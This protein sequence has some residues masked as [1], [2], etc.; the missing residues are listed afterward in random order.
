[1]SLFACLHIA[2]LGTS[3]Q[4]LNVEIMTK[5]SEKFI[6]NISDTRL[7]D[8]ERLTFALSLFNLNPSTSKP[9]YPEILEE[10]YKPEREDEIKKYPKCL[11]CCVHYLGLQEIYPYDLIDKVLDTEFIKSTYGK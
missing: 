1:M 7:K 3:A 5:I 6:Q 4:F 9:I 2:L 11:S 10:L 8:L